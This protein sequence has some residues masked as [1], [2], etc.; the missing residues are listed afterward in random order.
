[1]LLTVIS[2]TANIL[3]NPQEPH[4]ISNDDS[5]LLY[6]EQFFVE[7]SHGAYVYGYSIHDNYAGYV[8]HDQLIKEGP[9]ANSLLI[10]R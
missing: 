5:Q 9:K 8:E 7:E 2:S 4:I 3:G 1:M 6:G 10:A